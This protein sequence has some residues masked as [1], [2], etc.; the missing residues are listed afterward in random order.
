MSCEEQPSTWDR[1]Q[2]GAKGVIAM[3]EL[4]FLFAARQWR[5]CLGKR[6][7]N[8]YFRIANIV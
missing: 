3:L 6:E 7:V 4:H 1:T 5:A 2:F 8:R